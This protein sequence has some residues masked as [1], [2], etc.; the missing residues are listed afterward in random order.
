MAVRPRGGQARGIPITVVLDRGGEGGRA[1]PGSGGGTR[2]RQPHPTRAVLIIIT[3]G[4]GIIIA[5][6]ILRKRP[7]GKCA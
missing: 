7:S 5:G 6:V 1:V 2:L 3:D 4:D